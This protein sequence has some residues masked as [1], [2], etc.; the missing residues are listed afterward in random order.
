MLL[1]FVREVFADAE[2]TVGFTRL[3]SQLKVSLQQS[4][5]GGGDGAGRIRVSGLTPTAKLLHFSLLHRV[6]GRPLLLLVANNRAAEQLLPVLRAFCELTGAASASSVVS[7]PAYDV[8]PFENLSPHPEI[9]ETRASTLWKIVT[10][11]ASVVVAPIASAAMCLREQEYYADLAR[12][13][14]KGEAI[15]AERLVEHLNT[16]GYSAVDVAEMPGQY[17]LRGGI[18]DSYPPEAERPVRIEFF[19][20][21]VESMRSF[22]PGSQR[23]QTP[24]DEVVLLP[25][26]ET[27]VSEHTLAAIHTR[28][29]GKRVTGSQEVL[30][31][32]MASGGV[33]IFPGWEFYAPIAGSHT[34]IF[35]LLPRAAVLVDEPAAMNQEL[36]TW[37]EKVQD[38]HERS[39]IGSL[40]RPEELYIPPQDLNARLEQ[41]PGATVEC[42]N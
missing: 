16:V 22:D 19:G 14:R 29:S 8:L 9:Q 20:D 42:K 36:E 39:N 17:A 13:I 38:A 6:L 18:L 4:E 34:T 28:L 3:V 30:Q 23:S 5:G 40:V 24:R 26:T 12:V 33:S 21:E 27:P 15:D 37:W 1:P 31:Q 32:A 11:S 35:D 25:L 41:L 7:L 10:G 2:K